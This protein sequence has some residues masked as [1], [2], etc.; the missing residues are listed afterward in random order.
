VAI[1]LVVVTLGGFVA[2]FVN[3]AFATG[4]IYIV[5]ATST[6]VFPVAVAV[7]LQ[8]V[9]AMGSLLARVV[10][11]WQHIQWPIV[12]AF[13]A[14]S[15]VGVYLGAQVFVNLPE[16]LIALLLG[17]L[18]LLLIWMPLG[19]FTLPMKHPF[20]FVGVLHSFI[21]TVFGVGALLQPTILRT[22]LQKLAITAT[23][24]ACLAIMD[25]FKIIGYLSHGFDY[26]PY[27]PHIALA[28]IAGFVGTWC[29]KRVTHRISEST[30][31]RVFKWLV[32][33]VALQLLYRGSV[34]LG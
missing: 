9:F 13:A 34:A 7:P 15:T 20:A 12:L 8:S 26:R 31:R 24:A 3:A 18:L 23:L 30:F 17:I 28:V 16:G 19:N 25:V 11:F 14:G 10:V 22:T 29:G 27:I 6:A 32:T 33:I 4:G 21:G 1:E 5:L 2:S